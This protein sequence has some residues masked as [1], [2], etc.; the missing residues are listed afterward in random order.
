[1][2]RKKLGDFMKSIYLIGFMGSGKTT[3]GKALS[4]SLNIP[5]MDSDEE[6]SRLTGKTIIEIF[7]GE[8]EVGFRLLETQCLRNLP[9]E[10][11]IITTGGGI[12][13]REENRRWMRE[14]GV[15]V[16]LDASSEEILKRLEGDKTR[17]L[18]I[19]DKET[20]VTKILDERLPL[21]VDT[22]N[23][24]IET[25]GKS[26]EVIVEELVQRLKLV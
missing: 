4:L 16:L 9:V 7:D 15:V 25:T 2:G 13:L 3:I 5:V 6:V 19:G 10:N 18:L 17:P 8:G 1:M 21:Y 26:V 22:A 12:V 20:K 23:L 14:N 11:S 24:I